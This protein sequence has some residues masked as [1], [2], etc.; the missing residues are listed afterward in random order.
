MKTTVSG[1]AALHRT[2]MGNVTRV[3]QIRPALPTQSA[4]AAAAL[5]G[6][7]IGFVRVQTVRR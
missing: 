7:R 5:G 6:R 3:S 4:R 1:K 2:L